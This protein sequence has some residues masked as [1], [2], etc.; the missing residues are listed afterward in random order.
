M[1]RQTVRRQV[2][3][4][5]IVSALAVI[6][7][8]VVLWIDVRTGLW[9]EVVVLSG[10]V[11]GLITFLLTA[12][13]LRSTLARANARRWAPVNRLA[14]TEFL[15]AIADEQRSELSRGIV[16][17]RSLSLATR[18]GADQ[19]THDELEALRTQAL[20]DRQDLSRA[21]SSWAEFLATNSDDDPVLLHVAQIAIQLDLVRD[22]AISQETAPT[23]ENTAQLRAAITESNGRFAALVDELQRQIRV[24]DEDS[25]AS[26]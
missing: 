6:A 9:S 22:C 3:R 25:T 13:V 15:H 19:P 5:N 24:H 12:F 10:I 14:L 20:R 2:I 11:G 1:T 4:Q 8:L 17:A 18:D 21:L 26:H 16:V 7:C 23:A